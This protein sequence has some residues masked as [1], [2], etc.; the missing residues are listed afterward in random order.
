MREQQP[1]ASAQ[2]EGRPGKT[3]T[4]DER[5]A[6]E[7]DARD[8]ERGRSKGTNAQHQAREFIGQQ[9]IHRD[10]H[11]QHTE[12]EGT[13]SYHPIHQPAGGVHRPVAHQ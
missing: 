4:P 2:G 10:G 8:G 5:Q 11:L 7:Q 12:A 9:Q 1:K 13:R 6:C 3:F